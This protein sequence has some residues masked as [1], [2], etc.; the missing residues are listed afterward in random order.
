MIVTVT[1]NAAL[2]VSYAAGRLSWD[3]V[4]EVSRAR[5]LASGRGVAVARV[6]HKFGHDVLATGLAGGT[7]GELIRADLARTGIAADFTMIGRESRRVFGI[8]EEGTGRVL[9]FREPGPYVTTE[10]LGR[11]AADYRRLLAD[12]TGIV[13]CGSL[14]TGLPPEIYGSLV[15]YA[16]EAG[17]PVILDAG[18][19]ELRYGARR[20]PALVIPGGEGDDGTAA[21]LLALGPGAVAMLA[22]GGVRAVTRDGEWAAALTAGAPQDA[23]MS[24]GA[25]VAGLVPGLLLGWSW[26]DRLRH[27]LALASTTGSAGEVN[28]GAYE[29]MLSGDQLKVVQL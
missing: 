13:L 21:E 9:R 19:E 15:S 3:S 12:A 8:T 17:V 1:L 20:R 6:L 16:A 4:G 26:P 22:G 27:A 23:A 7:S 10:E 5:Y 2:E 29:Q 25:L 28:L 14:P 11:F 18:G 24:R